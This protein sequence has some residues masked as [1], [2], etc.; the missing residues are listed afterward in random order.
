MLTGG[1]PVFGLLGVATCTR[2]VARRAAEAAPPLRA[3]VRSAVAGVIAA[4]HPVFHRAPLTPA[5]I[6]QFLLTAGVLVRFLPPPR[7]RRPRAV[8][9]RRRIRLAPSACWCCASSDRL[10]SSIF[11]AGA[12]PSRRSPPVCRARRLSLSAASP[13]VVGSDWGAWCLECAVLAIAESFS[14]L[15]FSSASAEAW[16]RRTSHRERGRM[17]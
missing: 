8:A 17:T 3:T 4:L 9:A 15:L 6:A 13:A 7:R 5:T 11:V 16:Q 14:T 12:P 1:A 10:R 2:A